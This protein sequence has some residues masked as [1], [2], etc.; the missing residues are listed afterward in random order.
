MNAKQQFDVNIHAADEYLRMYRELRDLK[1]LGAR[2]RLDQANQ[3]LLWLPRGAVVAALSSGR[4]QPLVMGSQTARASSQGRKSVPMPF[5]E[6]TEQLLKP[7]VGQRLGLV[8]RT[9]LVQ[10]GTNQ[11]EEEVLEDLLELLVRTA[12]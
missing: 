4:D 5:L 10:A 6:P 8:L 2:G 1:N 9:N 7:G 3:Y 11:R 12:G